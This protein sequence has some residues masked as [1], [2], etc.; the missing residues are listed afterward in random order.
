MEVK[1]TLAFLGTGASCGVPSFYCG[2]IACEEALAN[3][4]A[5]RGCASILISGTENTLIDTSPELRLQLSH[6]G[7]SD[8]ARVLIT[9]A[10]F[11]HVGGIPQLEFYVKLKT[12]SP[13][14]IYAGAEAAA[15]IKQQFG[16]MLDTLEINCIDDGGQTLTFEAAQGNG[17]CVLHSTKEPS[18]CAAAL[19]FDGVAYTPLPA[20]HA[21]GTFGFL[22]ETTATR[23]AYFPDT[24]PLDPSVLEQLHDLDYLIID[25]TFSGSNWMPQSHLSIDE[26]IEL[27]QKV[28]ARVTYLT[29]LAMHYDTPITLAQ[30]EEKLKPYEGSIQI[31]FDGLTIEI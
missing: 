13:I 9:H 11:D 26:A 17:S 29:H 21:K 5:A 12:G 6:A 20:K 18:L 23:L 19:T 31:P 28:G 4:K 3:P 14:P 7:V 27:S 1:H 10:H 16:F 8:I 25:A 24:G 30:L 2:C 22:I 15:A